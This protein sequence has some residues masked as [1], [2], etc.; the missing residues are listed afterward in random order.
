MVWYNRQIMT[1]EIAAYFPEQVLTNEQI[2]SWGI[3]TGGK[4]LT[5]E[6]IFKKVGVK[7]RYLAD[8]AQNVLDMGLRAMKAL[9]SLQGVDMI[10]FSTSYPDG[11]N[12]A[13][14][15]ARSNPTADGCVNIHAACSGFTLGLNHIWKNRERFLG[16]RILFVASEKYSPTLVDLRLNQDDPS[17][18]QTIFS[19]GAAAIIFTAGQD[20][21]ILYA[22]NY[23]F[24]REKSMCLRMPVNHELV[25][26]PALT[27]NIPPSENGHFR[28][29]GKA[30]YEQVRETVPVLI[31]TAIERAGLDK[32]DIKLVI[33]HQA[34]RHLLEALTRR[35]PGLQTYS[36]LE[37]GNWSSASIPKAMR[38]AINEGVITAG[39]KIVLAGFGAGLFTSITVA[40]LG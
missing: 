32:K 6:A 26:H 23:S 37:D 3:Q 28:M 34:S 22:S 27:V 16:K 25:R 35:L 2:A 8:D 12:N 5:T 18:S 19:D 40:E 30:V 11:V 31:K 13:S 36:D 15:I 9:S 14:E 39:D 1:L 20:L 29:D 7:K 24:P 4:P 33:P 10:F 21:K 38:Q 17:L